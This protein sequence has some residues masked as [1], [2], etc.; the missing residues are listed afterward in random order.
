MDDYSFSQFNFDIFD[1]QTNFLAMYNYVTETDVNESCVDSPIRYSEILHPLPW[2]P[3]V[4]FVPGR[5]DVNNSNLEG[6]TVVPPSY[7]LYPTTHIQMAP[8]STGKVVDLGQIPHYDG[9]KPVS[10]SCHSDYFIRLSWNLTLYKEL[11]LVRKKWAL[12]DEYSLVIPGKKNCIKDAPEGCIGIYKDTMETSLRFPL[13]PFAVEVLN[14]YD[15]AV[16]ELYPN[17]WG[18]IIAFIIIVQQ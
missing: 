3:T 10:G 16:S 7:R 4:A 17:G 11:S 12:L 5:F 15:I 1:V 9:S 13:Y 6:I 2:E 14:A 18:C 8:T